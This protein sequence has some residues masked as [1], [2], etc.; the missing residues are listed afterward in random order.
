MQKSREAGRASQDWRTDSANTKAKL[1][2]CS[3]ALAQLKDCSMD[4]SLRIYR[5]RY[6]SF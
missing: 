5:A 3:L 6:E 1:L 4:I 2:L